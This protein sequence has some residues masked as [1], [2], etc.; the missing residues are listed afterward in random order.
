MRVA[1]VGRPRWLN[2]QNV[3]FFFSDRAVLDSFRDD[4]DLTGPESDISFAHLD[5]Q[6]A[7]ED[8]EEVVRVVVLM[9]GEGALD[10][11]DHEVVTVERANCSRLPVIRKGGKL[12]GQ[13]DG[14]HSRR[15][16][17]SFVTPNGSAL[18]GVNRAGGSIALAE[19]TTAVH[20]RC[21]AELGGSLPTGSINFKPQAPHTERAEGTA[22]ENFL[23]SE[24]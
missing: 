3:R 17:F 10:L 4:E 24:S 12:F 8:K 21:S 6:A 11:H 9:P 20:V 15:L 1:C 13:V 23:V 16:I 18:T 5:R 14:F 2:E 7:L 22:P 19:T